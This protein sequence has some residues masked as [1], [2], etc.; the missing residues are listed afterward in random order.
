MKEGPHYRQYGASTSVWFHATNPALT[1]VYAGGFIAGTSQI[2]KNGG[3]FANTTNLPTYIGNG[4]YNIILTATEMQATYI[5]L[6]FI[7]AAAA[8][9]P[10]CIAI[11]T[12]LI[13]SQFF[14]GADTLPAT[15]I[16][17]EVRGGGGGGEAVKFW[18]TVAD[19]SGFTIL[20]AG[21]G[22]GLAITGGA[23]GI[24]VA[25]DAGASGATGLQVRSIAGNNSGVSIIGSGTG[26]GLGI[27]GGANGIGLSVTAAGAP[28]V[29]FSATGGN[30]SGLSVVG[31]G[32]GPGLLATGGAT[33]AAG[34]A[35]VGQGTGVGFNGSSGS[36]G[37]SNFFFETIEDITAAPTPGVTTLKQAISALV[38]RFFYLV[39]QTTTQQK[40]YSSDSVTVKAIAAVSDDN[41]TQVK[42]KAS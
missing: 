26:A 1:A 32:S 6:T 4:L 41:V 36:A 9:L 21:T 25:I 35:G 31:F 15:N 27:T 2:S 34:I 14:I 23:T 29:Q 38:A 20:G 5:N 3:A 37:P 39:T 8:N 12:K 22:A 30:S 19:N 24:G 18:P 7:A 11:E 10:V 17:F 42:G 40:I 28:A 33:N 16:G 13:V